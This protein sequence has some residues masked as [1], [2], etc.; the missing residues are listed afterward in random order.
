MCG[1]CGGGELMVFF[2]MIVATLLA[3]ASLYP[4]TWLI[5]QVTSS[6]V[7]ASILLGFDGILTGI[8]LLFVWMW[9]LEE[10]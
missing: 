3:F 9:I 10:F 2:L 7:T 6:P 5:E 4:T 8:V 1:V